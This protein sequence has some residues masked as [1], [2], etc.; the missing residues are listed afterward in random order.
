MRPVRYSVAMSLDGF[1]AGPNGENDWIVMD[2]DIDFAA[3]AGSFDTLLLGRK[4]YE[5]ARGQG[6]AGMPGLRPYVSLEYARA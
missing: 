1:V 3:Q 4:T 6:G 5:S 2:P